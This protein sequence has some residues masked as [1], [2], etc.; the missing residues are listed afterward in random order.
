MHLVSRSE[1]FQRVI[2]RSGASENTYTTANHAVI[3]DTGQIQ[4]TIFFHFGK[5]ILDISL[6]N[7]N[8]KYLI[9]KIFFSCCYKFFFIF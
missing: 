8:L 1:T 7:E 6:S 3:T 4:K 5:Y 2:C 9:K